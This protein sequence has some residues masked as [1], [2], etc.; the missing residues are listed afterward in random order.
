MS[1][2]RIIWDPGL[3]ASECKNFA[4]SNWL[5]THWKDWIHFDSGDGGQEEVKPE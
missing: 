5:G 4:S 2:G 1:M 3:V